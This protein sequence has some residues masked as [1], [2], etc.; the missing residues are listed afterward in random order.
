MD[1]DE[2][3]LAAWT[4]D[5]RA[6]GWTDEVSERAHALLPTLVAVGYAEIHEYEP[7][8]PDW[9]MWNFTPSGIERVKE[10]LR[11]QRLTAARRIRELEKRADAAMSA[12]LAAAY[13][14]YAEELSHEGRDTWELRRGIYGNSPSTK[15]LSSGSGAQTPPASKSRW[16]ELKQA[17]RKC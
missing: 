13:L 1:A 3:L 11:Q 12:E 14:S 10:L 5:E 6:G 8:D 15:R 2:A 17:K 9:N 7:P 4:V 16:P